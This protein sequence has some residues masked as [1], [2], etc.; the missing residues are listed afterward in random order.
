MVAIKGLSAQIGP[1][2][3]GKGGAMAEP[4]KKVAQQAEDRLDKVAETVREKFDRITGGRSGGRTDGGRYL[5]QVDHGV[6]RGRAETRPRKR[7]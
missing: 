6:D 4:A 5:D 2:R 3:H 7:D 1:Y